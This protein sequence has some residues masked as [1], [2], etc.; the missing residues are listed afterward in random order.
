[1]PYGLESCG[2]AGLNEAVDLLEEG[3]GVNTV[4]HAGLLNGLTAGRRAAQAVHADG[5]EQRSGLRCDVENVADDGG[6]FNFSSL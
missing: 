5:H 4:D 6:L 3:V 2:L 1:M